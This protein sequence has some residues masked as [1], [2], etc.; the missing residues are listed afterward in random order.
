MTFKEYA[1]KYL[2]P[3]DHVTMIRMHSVKDSNTPF[4]HSE[5]STTPMWTVSDWMRFGSI[6]DVLILN[7]EQ[8]PID[9]LCGASWVNAYRKG[10]L[11]CL[12]VTDMDSMI[13]QYSEEQAK[14]LIDCCE[15]QIVKKHQLSA[16]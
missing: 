15:K 12:L 9:W 14:D 3:S 6:N 11:K 7:D 4:F 1:E 8:P 10:W 13:L 16:K 2:S 5:Y